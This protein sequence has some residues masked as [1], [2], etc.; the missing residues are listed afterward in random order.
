ML[1]NTAPN[2]NDP[3]VLM[4]MINMNAFSMPLFCRMMKNMC[5]YYFFMGTDAMLRE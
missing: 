4:S 3:E 1:G 5:N 2:G